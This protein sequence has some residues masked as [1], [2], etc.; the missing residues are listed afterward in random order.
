[1]KKI[2]GIIAKLWQQK[3]AGYTVLELLSVIM[4]S[5]IIGGAL[6]TSMTQLWRSDETEI[7]LTQTDGEMQA[8]LEYFTKDLKEAVFVY[9]NTTQLFDAAKKYI[10]TGTQLGL[11]A[12]T[13]PIFAFWTTKMIG[14]NDLPSTCAATDDECNN[15]LFR[16]MAYSLVVY[17][18]EPYTINKNGQTYQ[19]S[20]IYRYELPKYANSKTLTQSN[21]FVDPGEENNFLIWPLNGDGTANLQTSAPATTGKSEPMLL[22]DYVDN[23][24]NTNVVNLPNC[25][26]TINYNRL[27]SDAATNNSFFICVRKTGEEVGKKQDIFLYLRGNPLG[28]G[29]IV[30]QEEIIAMPT[31]KTQVTLRGIIDKK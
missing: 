30:K 15:L 4:I 31:Q 24:A 13:K 26:D 29:N 2:T 22:V 11:D 25:P 21:G 18:Q 19:K 23:P 17:Y 6:M 12:N 1:M 16:R 5:S 3:N 8:A 9:E 27:P 7:I 10:P 28:R 20:R 14:D